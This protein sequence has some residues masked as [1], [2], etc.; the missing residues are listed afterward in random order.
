LTACPSVLPGK[1]HIAFY[2]IQKEQKKTLFIVPDV[3]RKLEQGSLLER[4][5]L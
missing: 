1:K 5:E 3:I 2:E 4:K